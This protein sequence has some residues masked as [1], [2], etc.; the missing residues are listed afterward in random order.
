MMAWSMASPGST[1]QRKTLT[2]KPVSAAFSALASSRASAK[3]REMKMS[4]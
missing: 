2:P 3:R 1:A 4:G